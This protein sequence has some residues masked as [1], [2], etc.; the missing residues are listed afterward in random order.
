[1]GQQKEEES[2]DR[3]DFR[4]L[5]LEHRRAVS[6]RRQPRDGRDDEGTLELRVF[7]SD[8]RVFGLGLL[9]RKETADDRRAALQYSWPTTDRTVRHG[10]S[11]VREA[12]ARGPA[13]Y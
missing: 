12:G 3:F 7:E 4:G 9:A 13:D 1:V 8:R 6:R 2:P 10:D 5:R 11:D